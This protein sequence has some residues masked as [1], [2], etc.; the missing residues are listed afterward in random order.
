VG[1]FRR[2]MRWFPGRLSRSAG[3]HSLAG[4]LPAWENMI[5]T[6]PQLREEP[7]LSFPFLWCRERNT[8][9]FRFLSG[10]EESCDAVLALVRAMVRPQRNNIHTF[11]RKR[12]LRH[13]QMGYQNVKCEAR[14]EDFK[15]THH[16]FSRLILTLIP[17]KTFQCEVHFWTD[18]VINLIHDL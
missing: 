6:L 10:P 12:E 14:R 16:I 7:L 9:I 11:W 17:L 8:M 3:W 4:F 13:R 5:A 18:W 15:Y 2:G 1:A